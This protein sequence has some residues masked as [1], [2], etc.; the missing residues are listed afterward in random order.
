MAK[1]LEEMYPDYVEQAEMA[2]IVANQF[3]GDAANS[4]DVSKVEA[5]VFVGFLVADA[6]LS[7]E[8]KLDELATVTKG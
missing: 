7:L 5:I 2:E 8:R 6:I 3:C 1:T 4:V